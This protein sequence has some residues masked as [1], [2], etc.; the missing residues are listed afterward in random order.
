MLLPHHRHLKADSPQRHADVAAL[1]W[2]SPLVLCWPTHFPLSAFP[3]G[4]PKWFSDIHIILER[5]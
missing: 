2:C 4:W 5:S 1:P 3:L